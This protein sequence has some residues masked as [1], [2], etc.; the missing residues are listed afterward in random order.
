MNC[1]KWLSVAV[2]LSTSAVGAFA[3]NDLDKTSQDPNQWV[4]PLG[5]YSGIRHSKLS[6]INTRNAGKLKVAW[7]M[8][9][10]TLR[11]QEGQPLVVGNMMYFESS[12]PNFV[13]AIDLDK[14]GQMVWKFS[15]EQDK[16]SP[17]VAC[18]DLVNKGVAYADGKILVTTLD[19]H[20]YALDAKT[21]KVLWNAQNG[22]PQLGQT[23]TI[24]PLVVHDKVIVG[25]SGGEYG[26][27]GHLSA[28][29]LNTG[30]LAWRA[31][32]VG[33]DAD[34]L[35]D[36]D[37]TIDAA[38]Q[39]PVGKDSSLKSWRGDEWKLGGGTTW[40]WYTYDPQL[41]L[42][43]YGSGNPGTWN[44]SQRPGDN[45]WSTTL[46]ARN[47]D[48]GQAAWAYQMTPHDA[49]DYDGIN[50]SI[51]TDSA[52]DGNAVP[53]LTH[54]DRNGFAYVLDRRNGKLLKANKFDASTNWAKEIDL[55]TGR[56]VLNPDKVPTEDVN[57]KG[58]CPAAQGAKN[59]QPASYDPKT[60]LFY[61]GTNH[62][63]MDYQAFSVKYRGGFPYVGATLSMFPAEEGVRGR[64]I[65]F[66]QVTG[67]TKWTVPE[68]FQV[69][70]GPLT[71]DGGVLFYGTLDGWFKAVDQATGK[72]VY[73]FHAP[74][75][76]IG[77]PISYMHGGK[78]YVAV[79]TG[80]GGWA[81]IGLAEGLT[82][83]SEGLGAVGL[84][85]SL[86]DYTNLGGTLVVFTLE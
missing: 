72:V 77:N 48:T 73:Q 46:F 45:K 52:I 19:T 18:C 39:A 40:G 86:A 37:K 15:P 79:L 13:Y 41:N 36:A 29:D 82:K 31:Y 44:P 6:Q 32:S 30:K 17:S 22:D 11:G 23:M 5:S 69:Y 61:V 27:R 83:G 35:M 75:G 63:C 67:Q 9:T 65:A 58:I 81:A 51:L 25:I 54:F 64:L 4:L 53:T 68:M 7:T 85:A 60:K 57:V 42:V 76:I 70:S 84:T 28:Y 1:M 20:V 80:V 71:T 66:D 26:V 21:G 56:P 43:Y 16:Y 2:A 74:S 3:Q 59:H 47:P 34:T 50:E 12:Y 38:T 78:Q 10:G 33:P 55:K 14:V 62:I 24:A 8:S 49:W